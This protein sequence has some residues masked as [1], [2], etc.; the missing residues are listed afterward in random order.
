MAS[1]LN[2]A[3]AVGIIA[4]YEEDAVF[5]AEHDQIWCGQGNGKSITEITDEGK[6]ILEGLGWF[7]DENLGCWS[8][9]L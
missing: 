4:E 9:Y 7:I 2:I 1:A 8:L 5:T 6:E 3:K